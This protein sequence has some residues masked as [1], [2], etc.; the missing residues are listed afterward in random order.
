MVVKLQGLLKR[1][2]NLAVECS[3]LNQ[4]CHAVTSM[5][6]ISDHISSTIYI[7]FLNIFNVTM[8]TP[9]IYVVQPYFIL[10]EICTNTLKLRAS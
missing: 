10:T 2:S 5:S 3:K 9:S 6:D 4:A 1:F 8:V 7:L